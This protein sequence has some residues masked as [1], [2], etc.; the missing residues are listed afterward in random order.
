MSY[1][2]H[3]MNPLRWIVFPWFSSYNFMYRAKH[4]SENTRFKPEP[5]DFSQR[6]LLDIWEM[7]PRNRKNIS[8]TLNPRLTSINIVPIVL[9]SSIFCPV[10][11]IYLQN[12]SRF[13]ISF[14]H[15]CCNN[16]A[17]DL[18]THSLFNIRISRRQFLRNY[19]MQTCQA[20]RV[21]FVLLQQTKTCNA[22][23]I[24]RHGHYSLIFFDNWR[25][26]S[27]LF[28][29]RLSTR[30]RATDSIVHSCILHRIRAFLLDLS[31]AWTRSIRSMIPCS[32]CTRARA[33]ARS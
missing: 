15:Q 12:H 4:F 9:Y 31:V 32:S 10:P 17:H 5:C 3:W 18:I 29:G 13:N 28:S 22:S 7:Y 19:E 26:L 25:I 8:D 2:C 1:D 33:R 23:T 20:T 6:G 14:H 21:A 24:Y 30:A 27:I 16:L 11:S